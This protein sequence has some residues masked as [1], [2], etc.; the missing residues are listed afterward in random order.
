MKNP[1]AGLSGYKAKKAVLRQLSSMAKPQ[2]KLS[3]KSV[4]DVLLQAY[5]SGYKGKVAFHSY[6]E[7]KKLGKRPQPGKGWCIWSRPVDD[8]KKPTDTPE[9]GYGF[10]ISHVWATP[11]VIAR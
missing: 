2:A 4:N 7:W 1:Y 5:K 8:G 6:N 9:G 11:D 10:Y 3:G